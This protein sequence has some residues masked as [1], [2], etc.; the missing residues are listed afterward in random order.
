M[1]TKTFCE[2]SNERNRQVSRMMWGKTSSLSLKLAASRYLLDATCL[3]SANKESSQEHSMEDPAADSLSKIS[4]TSVS[5]LL[6]LPFVPFCSVTLTL[7]PLP[8]YET[9]R[10]S[11]LSLR[12]GS[13]MQIPAISSLHLLLEIQN[14]LVHVAI[15]LFNLGGQ[16]RS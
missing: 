6:L 1:E 15:T 10:S 14:V 12:S 5:S 9:K 3:K 7:V 11:R 4:L 16:Q 2:G 8:S 13:Q